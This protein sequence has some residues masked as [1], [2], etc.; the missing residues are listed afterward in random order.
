MKNTLKSLL[1]LGN[2]FDFL[3]EICCSTRVV[4][5]IFSKIS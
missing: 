3:C 5:G 4:I 1:L 2:M